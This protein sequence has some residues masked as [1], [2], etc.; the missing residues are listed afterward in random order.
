MVYMVSKADAL[1]ADSVD[2]VCCGELVVHR[3]KL[4]MAM[5]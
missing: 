2:P 5:E 4:G 3:E 1:G